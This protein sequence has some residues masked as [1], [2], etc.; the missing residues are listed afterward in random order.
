MG[1]D[2]T[3]IAT[4]IKQPF[5]KDHLYFHDEGKLAIYWQAHSTQAAKW[6]V[7]RYKTMFRGLG[8]KLLDNLQ[9]DLDGI[10]VFSASGPESIPSIF[11]KSEVISCQMRAR[12]E[13]ELAQ[14]S[15][16]RGV[17]GP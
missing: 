10:L 9:G 5:H 13:R 11:L 12:R 14:N 8:V 2:M 6:R 7:K 4:A 16:D 3:V 17:D 1:E 15:D